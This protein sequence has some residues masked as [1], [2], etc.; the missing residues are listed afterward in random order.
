MREKVSA[1]PWPAAIRLRRVAAELPGSGTSSRVYGEGPS[2]SP[3]TLLSSDNE[4][5]RGCNNTGTS[6]HPAYCIC[7]YSGLDRHRVSVASGVY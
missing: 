1:G 6:E 3:T 2:N 4:S 7:A 5:C